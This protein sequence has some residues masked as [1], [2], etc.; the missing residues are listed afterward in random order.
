MNYNFFIWLLL[1]SLTLGSCVS[2]KKYDEL[3]AD[4]K[5][6]ENRVDR[7]EEVRKSY[8]QL[9]EETNELR[10]D[11][12]RVKREKTALREQHRNL[13]AS[14]EQLQKE[15]DALLE[16][17]R[18]LLS[19]ASEDRKALIEEIARKQTALSDTERRLN[20]LEI[21][22]EQR[23]KD[24]N[25][26]QQSIAERE[27]RINELNQQLNVQR[28]ALDDIMQGMKQALL[29]F[30]DSELT[31]TE[32]NGRIYVSLSQELL[33]EKGSDR[34]DAKGRDAIVK[35]GEVLKGKSDIDIK[36]EGHTDSDG[37]ADRNWDLSASRATAVVK[38]LTRA[39]VDPHRVTAAGRA[40]FDP[41]APNDTEANKSLNRRT[42]IILSPDLSKLY[43]MIRS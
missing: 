41:V 15:Y 8:D 40:Y 43:D 21:D 6:L 1:A 33:F 32:K 22:L 30:S 3:L 26:L 12:D 19:S 37:S 17:N 29:G 4:N 35:V 23:E 11:C 25:N 16:E 7:L 42:E 20:R 24:L 39:G 36:V 34:I 2:Q 18:N 14:S 27:E 31:V 38:I 10:R 9:V 28:D 13:T 5:R